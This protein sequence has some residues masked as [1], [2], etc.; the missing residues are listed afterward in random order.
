MFKRVNLNRVVIYLAAILIALYC[1]GPLY[2]IVVSSFQSTAELFKVPPNWVPKDPTLVNYIKIFTGKAPKQAMEGGAAVEY[3]V[4]REARIFPRAILNSVIVAIGTLMV[5]LFV[6]T[7]SAYALARLKFAGNA[8][9]M[10][11]ILGV[12]MIPGLALIIPI[13]LMAKYFKMLD[14]VITLI[15]FNSAFSLPYTIW[16]LRAYFETIPVDLEDAAKLDG[17]SVTQTIKQIILPLSKPGLI[18][19]GLFAFMLSWGEFFY[20][21]ILTN[22]E[23]A[24][25]APVVT[26]MFATEVDINY[27]LMNT[28][29]VLAVIPSLA[30]ALVFQ[31]YITQGLLSGAVKG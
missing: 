3:A 30:F 29:A 20:A 13:Y 9:L 15:I 14:N 23:R 11:L 19:A 21:L 5:C 17:C 18:G 22:S 12:R 26:S 7:P 27:A 1:V 8:Q 2:W 28:A 6:G 24:F 10:F 25:T 4:P 16:L 31:K